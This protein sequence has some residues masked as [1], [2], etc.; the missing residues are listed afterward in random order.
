M[1]R[2][3]L[4]DRDLSHVNVSGT[5]IIGAGKYNLAIGGGQP[6]T[7]TAITN[8]EFSIQGE[9]KLPR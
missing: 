8:A 9:K 3:T 5:R 1:V 7:T 2:F 6:G 4:K